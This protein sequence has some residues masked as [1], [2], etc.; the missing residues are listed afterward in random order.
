MIWI[1]DVL[2]T[3]II[4]RKCIEQYW[5]ELHEKKAAGRKTGGW[6]VGEFLRNSKLGI[7]EKRRY[8]FTRR[9]R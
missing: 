6:N 8:E 5:R 7:A 2:D 4:P 1:R 9:Q 3:T